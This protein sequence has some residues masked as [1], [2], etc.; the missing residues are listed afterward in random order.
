M[1][2]DENDDQDDESVMHIATKIPTASSPFWDLGNSFEQFLN[3]C[4]VQSFLFLL[5]TCRDPQTVLWIEHFTEPMIDSY[6]TV[7]ALP[8]VP[9]GVGA[10]SYNSKL[11]SYHGLSA[12]NTTK[13]L[14]WQDYFLQLLQCPP[15]EYRVVSA[16]AHIPDYDHEIHPPRLCMRMLAVREQIARE[17]VQDLQVIAAQTP[18]EQSSSSRM[19]GADF[20]FL[21]F[22]PDPESDYASSPLR[23]G[24][25]DLLVLMTT[26]ESIH[27]LLNQNP[28]DG[29]DSDSVEESDTSIGNT[30]ALSSSQRSFLSNFYLHR[31]VSHFTGAQ[32][33]NRAQEFLQELLSLK[34][35]SIV[36]K[37]YQ[38]RSRVAMEWKDVAQSV[39]NSHV[40]I[41][42]IQ[43]QLLLKSYEADEDA[44]Q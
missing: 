42:K 19:Q 5:K 43:F 3:Q 23:K 35:L 37:I 28:V 13:F 9:P 44:V 11:L 12:M 25:F 18:P 21:E 36:F 8:G 16:A 7:S 17:F 1:Q 2:N 14:S 29:P 40:D 33:Y 41:Q 31:L 24:N 20:L 26:Q 15:V 34:E 6:S 4:T 10:G 38:Q 27:R 39:P 32:R 22:A 30:I